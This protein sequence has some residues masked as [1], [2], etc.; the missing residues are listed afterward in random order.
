MTTRTIGSLNHSD[1]GKT[2]AVIDQFEVGAG[3]LT[4]ISHDVLVS[5]KGYGTTIA[6]S[7][8]VTEGLDTLMYLPPETLCDF[9]HLGGEQG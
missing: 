3:I 5:R 1:L 7:D 9:P 2:I 6:L 8:P 4:F